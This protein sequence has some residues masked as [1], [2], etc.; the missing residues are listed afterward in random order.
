MFAKEAV[1]N[2]LISVEQNILRFRWCKTQA[3][4]VR[5]LFEIPVFLEGRFHKELSPK[6]CSLGNSQN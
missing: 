3:P 6:Q 5:D 2:R 4:V 1:K